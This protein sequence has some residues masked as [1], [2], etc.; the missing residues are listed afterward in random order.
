MPIVQPVCPWAKAPRQP[1]KA[2]K[3][4]I[5]GSG[6]VDAALAALTPQAPEILQP[7]AETQQLAESTHEE[8]D[9]ESCCRYFWKRRTCAW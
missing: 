7:S 5:L 2:L 4:G 3:A 8:I 1:W 9:A 6:Q